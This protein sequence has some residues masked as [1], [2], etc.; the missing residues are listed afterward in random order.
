MTGRR[1]GRTIS[2]LGV[3]LLA[4]CHGR[5]QMVQVRGVPFAATQVITRTSAAGTTRT[6]GRIARN[7]L[8]S[9][10]VEEVDPATGV[11]VRGLIVDVGGQ[12]LITLD[13]VRHR[14]VVHAAPGLRSQAVP[15]G[16]GVEM[17]RWAERQRKI[18]ETETLRGVQSTQV[19][20]GTRQVSGL[21]TVGTK[22]EQRPI[23]TAAAAA[24]AA[25]EMG[26]VDE[27]WFSIDLKLPVLMTERRPATGEVVE[28]MLTKILRAEPNAVLFAIPSDFSPQG[29]GADAPGPA[30][31][32]RRSDG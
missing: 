17:L 6:E 7:S 22:R 19:W 5:A 18:A 27:S 23:E 25:S 21:L 8:G 30:V 28:V 20:L 13:L 14:Y 31:D 15:T 3:A 26:Q 4:A 29:R 24:E 10:Y 9:T 16:S 1:S 32:S 2:L 12:R 11:A